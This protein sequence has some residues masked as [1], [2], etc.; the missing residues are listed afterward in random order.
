VNP[1]GPGVVP[2]PTTLVL[3]GTGLAVLARRLRRA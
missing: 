2:E 3:L 1:L